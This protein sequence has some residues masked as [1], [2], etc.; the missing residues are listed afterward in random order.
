[1]TINP[2][3]LALSAFARQ[4]CAMTMWLPEIDGRR[5]PVYRRIADAI[6]EDVQN[7]RLR[8][9]ARLP[10]HRDMA[11]HLGVTVTTVTRAYTEAARRGLISGHVGRGTFIRGQELEETS[12][13]GPIDLSVNVLMPD[14]EVAALEPRMF[15]R[16]VL[17]WTD[18]LGYVPAPGHRRHRQAM[19]EWLATLG[20]PVSPDRIVLTAG[21]QH[22]L[23]IAL[24]VSAKPGDTV[25]TE[26]FTYAGMKELARQMH[27]KVRGVAM[28]AEGLR[29][30]AL[31]TACRSTKSRVVYCMPR[32][33]NPT[34][35]VMS[36]RRRRQI[37]AVAEKHRLTV[38]EDDVYGFLSPERA[39][40]A[41]LIP[42]RTLFV[43]SVSKSLFPGMRLGCVV[44]PPAMF[45]SVSS[46]VWASMLCVSPISGDLLCGWLEDGTA[47]RILEWKRHEVTARQAMAKR[48][49]DGQRLQTSATSP[50]VW[51]H[52]PARWTTE[53]FV[54]EMRSRGVIVNAATAFAAGAP[55]DG[56]KKADL[57]APRA[58]RLCIGTPRTR[59]GLEQALSRLAEALAERTTTARAV[60]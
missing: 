17:P 45:D 43:T 57:P 23:M 24:T 2:L 44:S 53:G 36:E 3:A 29:P 33:Q 13:S 22:A 60:V 11:D 48:L 28:D 34:S 40:L 42:D 56:A 50:H 31:E 27:L 4:D 58:I 16:R 35:A 14:K 46:A 18:L 51:L 26:E 55:G 9:G 49:L 32:L 59:A 5:G 10:P 47:K 19:A 6:D 20:A 38:I 8:A 41:T 1:M 12:A 52:L 37:A 7:G 54:A 21:A 30:E 25:L 15:Q 39:P